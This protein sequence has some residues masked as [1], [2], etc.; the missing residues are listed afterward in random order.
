MPSNRIKEDPSQA[1][2]KNKF[3]SF[4]GTYVN[5]WSTTSMSYENLFRTRPIGVVSKYD[6]GAFSTLDS[7][8]KN[9]RRAARDPPVTI[10][11]MA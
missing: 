9:T 10:K 7:I 6:I 4:D 1:T 3:S 2:E 11:G 5:V 8:D